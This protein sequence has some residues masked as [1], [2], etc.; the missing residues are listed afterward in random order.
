[1]TADLLERAT[2]L[3]VVGRAGVGVDNVDTDA[4]TKRGVIVVNA[5][6]SNVVT[7]A[8]H[9]I[10][11]LMALARNVP[12]AAASMREGK[13]ERSRFSGVEL[14]GKTIGIIGFGRIG[15][16]VAERAQG[17]GMRVLGYDPYVGSERYRELGVD[18]ARDSEQVY[19]EADV[20]T[21]HLPKTPETANWLDAEAFARMKPGVRVLNVAR[22]GLVDEAALKDALDAGTVGGAALDVFPQEPPEDHPLRAYD[23]VILTPA[24]RRLHRG[25]QRPG[26]VPGRRADRRR[27][28]RRHRDDGGQRPRRSRA[29]TS[30][31]SSRSCHWPS[32]SA[33]WRRSSRPA[34]RSTR[35][36]SSRWDGS[37]R[38]TC[39][40]SASPSCAARFTVV[41]RRRSTTSTLRAWPVSAGS[42][43]RRPRASGRRTSATCSGSPSSP[44]ASATAWWVR[45][46]VAA[47]APHLLEAWGQRF[48][49]Q[50]QGSLLLLRYVDQPGMVGRIGALLG[51]AGVNIEQAAVSYDHDDEDVRGGDAVMVVT[52]D[53]PV[54]AEVL[55]R[56]LDVDAVHDGRA[57]AL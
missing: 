25:G 50:L 1:M 32:A 7:A 53:G 9:T 30:R 10:A 35:S 14:C 57:V 45:P 37:A 28:D 39:D 24:P 38:A 16:L 4:A 34:P 46:S 26:G 13:W 18:Q 29:R 40:P 48:N 11:L 8:E 36:R 33:A 2:S 51:E 15:Q 31:S 3:R 56:V 12:L 20:I 6:Q 21:I 5:P 47:S 54:P 23:Q 27:A 42:S 22:G 43:S 44:A 52:T 55:R 17:L 41:S 49:L 19:A